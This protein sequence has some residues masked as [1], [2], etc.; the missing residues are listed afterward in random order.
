MSIS[1]SYIMVCSRL[2][3]DSV[4]Y[5]LYSIDQHSDNWNSLTFRH[6]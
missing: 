1:Q 2:H 4:G 6:R 5:F 3:L